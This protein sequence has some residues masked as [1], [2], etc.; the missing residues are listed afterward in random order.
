MG[1]DMFLFKI[2]KG[3]NFMDVKNPEEIAYW[4]KCNQVHNWF[5]EKLNNGSDD[6]CEPLLVTKDILKELLETCIIVKNL[7]YNYKFSDSPDKDKVQYEKPIMDIIQELLPTKQ[8]FFF[9]DCEYDS[10]YYSQVELTIEQI[11]KI[12]ET[13]DFGNYDMY[14]YAWW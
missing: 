10:R 7:F 4:R 2:E 9:G 11:E 14:Y 13:F 12:L 8:G 5:I 6:D 3:K 1:L